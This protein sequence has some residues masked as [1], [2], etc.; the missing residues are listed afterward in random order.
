[1]PRF[2]VRRGPGLGEHLDD[3]RLVRLL[4]EER[5]A[6]L[7]LLNVHA[8]L[9]GVAPARDAAVGGPLMISG[10][11]WLFYPTGKFHHAGITVMQGRFN[12][13]SRK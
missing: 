2:C 5:E 6:V 10:L 11:Y 8:P 12:L 7:E 1:M 4:V 9:H 13:Y 3:E